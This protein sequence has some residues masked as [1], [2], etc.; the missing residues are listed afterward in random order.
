MGVKR[1]LLGLER[2]ASRRRG[3]GRLNDG[4]HF[5]IFAGDSGS[6]RKSLYL[7]ADTSLPGF[8]VT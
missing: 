4:R 5:R 7:V 6:A 8:R 2:N 3:G 1:R